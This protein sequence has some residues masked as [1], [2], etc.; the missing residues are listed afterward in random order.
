MTGLCEFDWANEASAECFRAILAFFPP[1][2]KQVVSD[3]VIEYH[4]Y[5]HLI[6]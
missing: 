3:D 2:W 6:K 1:N 4:E 5:N